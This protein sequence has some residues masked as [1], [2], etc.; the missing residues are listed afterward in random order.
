[1]AVTLLV[2][3]A[4][5]AEWLCLLGLLVMRNPYDRLHA[6]GP[7]NILPPLLIALA[8]L[9]K[10]GFSAGAIKAIVVALVLLVAGPLLTHAIGRAGRMEE[11]GELAPNDK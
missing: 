8:I 3:L 7:A 4:V 5:L 9:A 6:V 2:S 11:K 10:S 1:M